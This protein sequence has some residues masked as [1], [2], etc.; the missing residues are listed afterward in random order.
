MPRGNGG[1]A[2]SVEGDEL[3]KLAGPLARALSCA[4]PP[5]GVVFEQEYGIDRVRVVARPSSLIDAAA[6]RRKTGSSTAEGSGMPP[7][8]DP[9]EAFGVF[10]SSAR[11]ERV[12]TVETLAPMPTFELPLLYLRRVTVQT[13]WVPLPRRGVAVA[14]RFRLRGIEAGSLRR[15]FAEVGARVAE[16]WSARIGRSGRSVLTPRWRSRRP[17]ARGSTRGV[18]PGAWVE[19]PVD[20]LAATV[21]IPRPPRP[22]R[23][24]DWGAGH[25]AVFGASGS[26]KTSF[27]AE[28]GSAAIARGRPVVAI[29]V[30]G[31]L[32]PALVAR[33]TAADRSRLVLV[34]V[35]EPPVRGFDLLGGS[36][37]GIDDRA[38]AH[39]V[40]ALKR[41]T[42]DGE[43]IYWGFRLE[44]IFDAFVR[45]VQE[46]GGSIVDLAALLGSA[47]RRE[48]ARAK[49]RRPELAQFLEELAP[50]VRRHPDFLWPAAARL[51]K[52]TVVPGLRDLL[53]PRAAP[54]PIAQIL[55][56]RRSLVVRLPF[57]EI[58]P[59]GAAFAASLLWTRIYLDAAARSVPGDEPLLFLIDE[60][61]AI[62]P[63]LLA[64]IVTE[65][66]KFGIR[67]LVATQYPGRFGREVE[68]AL[69]G[70]VRTH[71]CFRV[72]RTNARSTAEWLGR[73]SPE[74]E[75]E[76][77]EI[78]LGTGLYFGGR[79]ERI[80]LAAPPT[81]DPSSTWR[82]AIERGRR[83]FAAQKEAAGEP[84]SPDLLGES[85]LVRLLLAAQ[86]LEE[87]AEGFAP[88][89]LL[90]RAATLTAPVLEVAEMEPWLAEAIRRQWIVGRAPSLRLG[91]R[92]VETLGS[93]RA[94]GAV[95]ESG[96]HRNL[97]AVAQRLL[98][99]RGCRLEIV[100]QGRFDTPLP[101]ARIDLWP[102]GGPSATPH[103]RARLL[104]EV[105]AGWAWRFFGGR[106]VHVEAEVSGAQRPERIRHGLAKAR[107]ADAFTLFL[108]SEPARARRIRAILR[109]NALV[110]GRAQV[111]TL[112]AAKPQRIASAAP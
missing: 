90:E 23:G 37:G 55:S 6:A 72:P 9:T 5:A 8:A 76:L 35:T 67:A 69:A 100:R 108:V 13:F 97:I 91:T 21:D 78:P 40:A 93:H 53:A 86:G 109:A 85:R 59:E 54:L 30:H 105:R 18:P 45:L 56:E 14:R 58:G 2:W 7:A 112:P 52:V 99:R 84:P 38:A 28:V 32:G 31:D 71:V 79:C 47:D 103:E 95:R 20:R 65:G 98:A 36:D 43:E 16:D 17:W 63:R 92:G 29:D 27:L 82:S 49:T 87:G 33:L 102:A 26:G 104:D 1:V 24:I 46:D 101:D 50:V 88:Q 34:D 10:I 39:L 68:S 22:A 70:S 73:R 107:Q 42:A 75:R 89:A 111:W 60:A 74:F 81:T 64:E 77:S 83:E 66:R 12:P 110:P 3:G 94:S 96:E 41:L 61:Q 106:N 19:L 57:A 80:T 51:A 48:A 4:A 25:A 11:D 62:S 44:R 15:R